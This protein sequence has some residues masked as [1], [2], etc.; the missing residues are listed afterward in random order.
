MGRTAR[1]R[2]PNV[3]ITVTVMATCSGCPRIL[4]H[5]VT[6][7]IVRTDRAKVVTTIVITVTVT[8]HYSPG[9]TVTTRLDSRERL[10]H[11]TVQGTVVTRISFKGRV[12]IRAGKMGLS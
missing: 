11:I 5:I 4:S 1:R 8:T 9:Y 7:H 6:S 2:S 3:P 10:Q 12:K